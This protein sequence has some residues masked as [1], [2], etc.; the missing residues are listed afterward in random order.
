MVARHRQQ[1]VELKTESNQVLSARLLLVCRS[2][3]A[4]WCTG[5]TSVGSDPRRVSVGG[6]LSPL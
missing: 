3:V 1:I 5:R 6:T 4:L 2:A